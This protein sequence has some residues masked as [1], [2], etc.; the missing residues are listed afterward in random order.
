VNA[1]AGYSLAVR[2]G[3]GFCGDDFYDKVIKGDTPAS[4]STIAKI[5]RFRDVG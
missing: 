1:K 3:C 5:V 2:S 4:A